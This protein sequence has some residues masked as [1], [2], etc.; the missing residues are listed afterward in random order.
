LVLA[1]FG[2]EVMM[3]TQELL[4]RLA[5][6]EDNFVER[7]PKNVNRREI[8][9]T[10]V[11]F[12]NSVPEG[13]TGVLFIGVRDDGRIEGVDST[14][15]QSEID[16][17]CERDCYPPVKGVRMEAI[18]KE[19][20]DVIAVVIPE[21]RDKPHF[22]GQAYV[23]RGSKSVAASKEMFEDLITSRTDVG[24]LLLKLKGSEVIVQREGPYQGYRAL[25]KIV[26]SDSYQVFIEAP[27]G[28]AFSLPLAFVSIWWEGSQGK[29]VI[30]EKV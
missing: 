3:T 13:R 14:E 25:G 18:R 1:S 4:D 15:R 23:R 12:A 16:D 2:L 20:R 28:N 27:A 6:H 11:A 8:R 17:I 5:N 24:R 29:Y 30:K 9:K 26:S 22:S 10:V 19:G 7:K 21:S